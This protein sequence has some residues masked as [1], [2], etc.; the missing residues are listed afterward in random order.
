MHGGLIAALAV[1]AIAIALPP[2]AQAAYGDIGNVVNN[3][4]GIQF[5]TDWNQDCGVGGAK[6]YGVYKTTADCTAPQIPDKDRT[7][8]RPRGDRTSAD[9]PDCKYGIHRTITWYQ[10]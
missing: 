9:G 7:V 1:P 10:G 5:N 8:N 2:T 6:Y 4:Y 3:C